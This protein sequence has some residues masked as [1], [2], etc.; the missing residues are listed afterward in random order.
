[1]VKQINILFHGAKI[2]IR[3]EIRIKQIILST[4]QIG[5]SIFN[6]LPRAG[7]IGSNAWISLVIDASNIINICPQYT[8]HIN[9]SIS[10]AFASKGSEIGGETVAIEK[11]IAGSPKKARDSM[12]SHDGIASIKIK[13]AIQFIAIDGEI[14]VIGLPSFEVKNISINGVGADDLTGISAD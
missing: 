2:N 12:S 5:K 8:L 4:D 3:L 14:E 1:M 10:R 9:I 6:Q 13:A 7:N 11:S